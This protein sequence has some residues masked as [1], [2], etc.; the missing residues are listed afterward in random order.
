M[1]CTNCKPRRKSPELRA[2]DTVHAHSEDPRFMSIARKAE[3][4]EYYG[5]KATYRKRR[6]TN[7]RCVVHTVEHELE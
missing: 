7:C 5:P 4:D 2:I 3:L 1:H 6:C